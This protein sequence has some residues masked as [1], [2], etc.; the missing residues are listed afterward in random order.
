MAGQRAC[1]VLAWLGLMAGGFA[2]LLTYEATPAFA[3]SAPVNNNAFRD[4]NHLSLVL[5]LH[6]HCPCSRATVGELEKIYSH[7]ANEIKIT[8][9]TFKPAD[10]PDSWI[11][12]STTRAIAKMN[13]K[14]VIDT[15]GATARQL[16][17]TTSGQVQ[18]YGRDGQLLYNGGITSGRGHAG[19]NQGEEAVLALIRDASQSQKSLPTFGCSLFE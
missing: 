7:T 12:S 13:A 18:L 19:D 14:V 2:F 15:D 3:E 6:P 11:E 10:E 17:L 5:A 9:L 4:E 8:V 16:G 1:L